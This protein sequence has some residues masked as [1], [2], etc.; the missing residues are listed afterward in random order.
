MPKFHKGKYTV[1]NASKYSG[2]GSPTFRSSWEQTFMQFCDNNP[3]VMAWAS[4]PV[5]ITYQNPLTGKVT[6]YVPDFIVV[7]RDAKG[8]KN[9]E[10]IEIKPANQSNP[11]FARGRTQQA[12]VAVNFAKWDAATH[13]AKKR[14]MKF[15]V[16]NENDIYSNTKKPKVRKN[17]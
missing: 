2:S 17:K 1:L 15:R 3:N 4:E 6:A 5:K 16:L 10:L 9:A 7:Y 11:K 12:Q 8:K 14:G 13:W